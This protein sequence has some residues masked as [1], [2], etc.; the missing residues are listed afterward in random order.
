MNGVPV[1][2]TM[3]PLECATWSAEFVRVRAAHADGP[4]SHAAVGAAI[5]AADQAVIDL[6]DAFGTEHSSLAMR[7]LRDDPDAQLGVLRRRLL[8]GASVTPLVSMDTDHLEEAFQKITELY[9]DLDQH[10]HPDDLLVTSIRLRMLRVREHL[11][12]ARDQRVVERSAR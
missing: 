2:T 7:E 8:S 6:R 4:S 10:Q 1:K 3:S 12:H 5:E 11:V 9:D